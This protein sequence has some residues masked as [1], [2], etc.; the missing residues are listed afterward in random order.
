MP[1]STKTSN[2]SLNKWLGTDKPKKDDFNA[3]NALVDAAFARLDTSIANVSSAQQAAKQNTDAELGKLSTRCD[4][5]NS[6]IS[7][8]S[9]NAV[10]HLTAAER[11]AWNN[12]SASTGAEMVLGTYVGTGT[13]SL[14]VTMGFKPKFGVLFAVGTGVVEYNLLGELLNL[15]SAYF[16]TSGCSR[17]VALDADGI[18]ITHSTSMPSNGDVYYYNISGKTY[19]Y[20]A[21][22]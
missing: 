11:A 6:A 22:K 5:I 8:H 10:V 20:A 13:A 2:L 18:T 16:S 3:D 17:N 12:A 4:T 1:S 19:V 15:Y 9:S 14:K 21:W 7:T